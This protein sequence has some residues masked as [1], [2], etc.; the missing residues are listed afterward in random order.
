MPDPLSALLK[1]EVRASLAEAEL[2]KLN[3]ELEQRVTLRT[4]ELE[5]ANHELEAFSYSV[6]HDLRA[7]LRQILGFVDLLGRETGPA[8]SGTAQQHLTD[9]ADSAK[10]MNVLINTL[11]EFSRVSRAD[12]KKKSVDLGELAR[13]VINELHKPLSNREI[14]WVINPLPKASCD[15]TLIR[16]V[17]Y[18]LISNALKY[19]RPRAIARI[20]IGSIP[21]EQQCDLVCYVRDNGVGFDPGRAHKLFGVFQRLHHASV[22]EGTGIGLANVQRIIHRHGGRVWAAGA[23]DAGATFCFSLPVTAEENPT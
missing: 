20:E 22:F 18:N 8:L 9:I 11:L 4:R 16:Q 10:R 14:E 3:Q 15:P 1:S 19:S 21:S 5:A 6:S 7:P 13:D 12:L 23:V 17:F 2:R